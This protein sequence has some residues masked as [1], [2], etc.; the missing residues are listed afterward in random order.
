MMKTRCEMEKDLLRFRN[1]FIQNIRNCIGKK[2]F[3]I[4]KLY[5]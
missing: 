4:V 1:D 5:I 3:Q 2:I